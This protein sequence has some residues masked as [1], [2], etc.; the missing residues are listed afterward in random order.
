MEAIFRRENQY[1]E[2]FKL[3]EKWLHTVLGQ[4]C[5]SHPER[6]TCMLSCS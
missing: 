4:G 1:A 2:Y 3:T 5:G 6:D